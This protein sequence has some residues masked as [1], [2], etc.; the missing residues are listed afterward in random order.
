MDA[1]SVQATT[2]SLSRRGWGT[3]RRWWPAPS[4]TAAETQRED[5]LA[6]HHLIGNPVQ[7]TD[8]A[9]P[10]FALCCIGAWCK[11]SCC[12]LSFLVYRRSLVPIVNWWYTD[13]PCFDHIKLLPFLPASDGSSSAKQLTVCPGCLI[14]NQWLLTCNPNN[15]GFGST[16]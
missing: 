14:D 5:P 10:P 9:L 7:S 13:L 12:C 1:W 16:G 2:L 15:L 6:F 4:S 3:G 8:H 11:S